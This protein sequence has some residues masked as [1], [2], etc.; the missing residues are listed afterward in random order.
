MPSHELIVRE[1]EQR[2]KYSVDFRSLVKVGG[3]PPLKSYLTQLWDYRHFIAYDASARVQDKTTGDR[4]GALWLILNPILMGIAFYFVFG[5]VMNTQGGIPNFVG[6]L[7]LGIFLFQYSTKSITTIAKTLQGNSAVVHSFSF[8]RIALP[9]AACLRELFASVPAFL[10]M[11]VLII[12]LP[13]VET[14]TPLW[15][16]LAPLIVI[17]TVFNLGIG[18]IFARLV[19]IVPDIAHLLNFGMRVLM[20]AS[21]VFFSIDRYANFPVMQEIMYMN[22]LFNFLDIARDFI[23][24]ETWPGWQSWVIVLGWAAGSLVFGVWFFWRG[25][26]T[27]GRPNKG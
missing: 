13:P 20:Y 7:I 11:L 4:L 1:P 17:Q 14:I 25:E 2:Q 26:E 19:S 15:L 22:P 5:L 12:A 8:P 10:T 6:Y 18:L 21:A 27:Y 3:R 24:Y 23:L 16:L 9:I